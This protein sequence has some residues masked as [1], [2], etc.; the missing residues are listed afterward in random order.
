M[1]VS[2]KKQLLIFKITFRFFFFFFLVALRLS[3]KKSYEG[4]MYKTVAITKYCH[5]YWYKFMKLISFRT[6]TIFVSN[7]FDFVSHFLIEVRF[8]IFLSAVN[9]E[10]SSKA[11]ELTTKTW[12]ITK[13]NRILVSSV[14]FDLILKRVNNYDIWKMHISIS[15][16]ICCNSWFTLVLCSLR[17]VFL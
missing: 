2:D 7:Y 3:L 12:K 16:W 11:L 5:R 10:I 6:C 1:P 13:W 14:I 8:Q 15:I 17:Q 9:E 4:Y